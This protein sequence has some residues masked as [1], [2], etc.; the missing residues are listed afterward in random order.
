VQGCGIKQGPKS[1]MLP[2]WVQNP[3]NDCATILEWIQPTYVS[4]LTQ[5]FIGIPK[6][7][8]APVYLP[9]ISISFRSAKTSAKLTSN[10]TIKRQRIK[11][12]FP[13]QQLSNRIFYTIDPI[14]NPQMIDPHQRPLISTPMSR[15]HRYQP[16]VRPF[17][18][19]YDFMRVVP[20]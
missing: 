20:H 2:N 18:F 19:K 8:A 1:R 11:L 10:L 3:R 17:L 5:R 13:P 12:P 14:D 16:I 4:K 9:H 6:T 7:P 15:I